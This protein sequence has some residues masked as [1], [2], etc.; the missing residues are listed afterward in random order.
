VVRFGRKSFVVGAKGGRLVGIVNGGQELAL[1]TEKTYVN[2]VPDCEVNLPRYTNTFVVQPAT[3]LIATKAIVNNFNATFETG[4]R[5]SSKFRP[6]LNEWAL[7]RCCE[8]M[9]S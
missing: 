3:T 7:L 6:F 2:V 4:T 5:K 1:R 9:N 8:W